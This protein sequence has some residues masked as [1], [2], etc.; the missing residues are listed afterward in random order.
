MYGLR[1]NYT[2][3]EYH[4]IIVTSVVIRSWQRRPFA[5]IHRLCLGRVP[6]SLQREAIVQPAGARAARL[7]SSGR[8]RTAQQLALVLVGDDVDDEHQNHKA[9][10]QKDDRNRGVPP[11]E[12]QHL[13]D[14]FSRVTSPRP[15]QL[16]VVVAG[17][18]IRL[19]VARF[20]T[21]MAFQTKTADAGDAAAGGSGRRTVREEAVRTIGYAPALH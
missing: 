12:I 16:R 5:Q 20:A 3:S 1:I 13:L 19:R 4:L 18:A 11:L 15:V 7:V 9:Q 2:S 6:F 21:V 8:P 17:G 10:T 14:Q